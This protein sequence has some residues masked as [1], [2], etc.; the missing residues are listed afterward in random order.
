MTDKEKNIT[1]YHEAGH[2]LVAA[3]TPK[4]EPVRKISIISRGMAA[5][6]TLKVPREDRFLRTKSEFEAELAVLLAGYV[7][8]KV[9]FRDVTTGASDDLAKASQLARNIVKVYGMSSLGPLVFGEKGTDV[10][11]A[12]SWEKLKII[13]KKWLWKLTKK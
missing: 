4:A 11:G 3:F 6:Y 1:A 10:F 5:G 7:S 9:K 13:L 12:M 8:E 2:A